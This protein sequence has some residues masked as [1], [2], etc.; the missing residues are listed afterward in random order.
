MIHQTTN[1]KSRRTTQPCGKLNPNLNIT[2]SIKRHTC[3]QNGERRRTGRTAELLADVRLAQRDGR[4][5]VR[6]G[7]GYGAELVGL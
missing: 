1:D 6:A 4:G 5:G 2:Q 7:A 3:T